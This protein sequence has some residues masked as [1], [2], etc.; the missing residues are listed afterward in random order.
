MAE[1]TKYQEL[2]DNIEKM[3][4]SLIPLLGADTDKFIQIA[5]NYIDGKNRILESSS[6][7]L[8]SEIIKAAQMRLFVDGQEASIVPFKGI[9]KLMV[10]YKGLLKM[11]RNSGELASINAN[12]VYEADL[13]EFYTDENGEH[14]KHAPKFVK[15]RGKPIISFCIARIK[16]DGQ[17]YVEVMTEDEVQACKKMSKSD[18]SPWNGPFADEMRKKTVIRRISKRLPMSTDLNAAI[19]SDDEFF[20][21]PGAHDPEKAPESEKTSSSRLE[22]A[23]GGGE[24][25][26]PASPPPTPKP[27]PAKQKPVPPPP[28]DLT[29]EQEKENVDK[30]KETFSQKIEGVV[31]NI[32]VRDFP[33][34]ELGQPMRRRY[35][36][37]IG[38]KSFGTWDAEV[39]KKIE[40]AYN[41]ATESILTF[42]TL[43]NSEKK[44]YNDVID[45][46]AKVSDEEIPI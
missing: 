11:V 12:V 27:A 36:C 44:A 3:K 4:D 6:A 42:V 21:T 34:A 15:D 5:C 26:K 29:P 33:G 25:I 10:G 22:N 37:S 18:E 43:L 28:P 1:I 14:I 41:R 45:V 17:P 46:V 38:E 39:Y 31:H 32:K 24:K 20:A 9:C 30:M 2:C 23:V 13:F 40:D 16:G 8:Y 7:S 35:S 19:H